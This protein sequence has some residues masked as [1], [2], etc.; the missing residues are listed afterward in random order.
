VLNSSAASTA[1]WTLGSAPARASV[2]L[3]AA[4]GSADTFVLKLHYTLRLLQREGDGATEPRNTMNVAVW[5]NLSLARAVCETAPAPLAVRVGQVLSCSGLGA[6]AV[7]TATA[8]HEPTE[9]VHGELGGLAS[10]VARALLAHVR[11]V[12]PAS[13]L[14]A[15]ALPAAAPLL[16]ANVTAMLGGRLDFTD[17][18]RAACSASAQ[19]HLR[20][21][22]GHG[23]HFVSSCDAAAQDGARAWLRTA[24]GVV[25][26]AGHVQA[27]CALAQAPPRPYAY[28]LALVNTRAYLPRTAQWHD[29]QNRSA[30]QST[31][32]L[33]ALFEFE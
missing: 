26:D 9:T 1:Q 11:R 15:F 29:L 23:V 19:C 10:F 22:Y 12:H 33:F 24:L 28:T 5:R 21:V 2:F 14:A 17:T 32:R 16:A 7:A 27:L 30:P 25:H 31:S 4:A 6:S 3:R 18:F 20:Y 8:L 13:V